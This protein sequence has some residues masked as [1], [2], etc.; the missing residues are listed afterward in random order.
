MAIS[1]QKLWLPKASQWY[2]RCMTTLRNCVPFISAIHPDVVGP[3]LPKQKNRCMWDAWLSFSYTHSML[4]K[5]DPHQHCLARLLTLEHMLEARRKEKLG[6]GNAQHAQMENDKENAGEDS[7]LT[8][9]Q[10][11]NKRVLGKTSTFTSSLPIEFIMFRSSH[12]RFL[13]MVPGSI[14]LMEDIFRS[15]DVQYGSFRKK[16]ESNMFSVLVKGTLNP[17]P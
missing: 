3:S 6:R 1:P 5:S 2:Q 16:G 9:L 13:V 4:C 12:M 11:T 17:K 7:S 15:Q 8:P 14:L 10:P